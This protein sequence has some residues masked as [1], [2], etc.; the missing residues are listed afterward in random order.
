[1]SFNHLKDKNISY[2][3]HLKQAFWISFRLFV[4][5]PKMVVHGLYPDICTESASELAI[6]ILTKTHPECLVVKT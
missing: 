6:D 3:D 5:I 4:T 2:L 1:M